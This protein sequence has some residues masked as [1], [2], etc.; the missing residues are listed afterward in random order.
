MDPEN[1]LVDEGATAAPA[2]VSEP[3]R[4]ASMI[5]RSVRVKIHQRENL[6]RRLRSL[7]LGVIESDTFSL[8]QLT[9][10]LDLVER[11]YSTLETLQTQLE[12]LDE[13]QLNEDHRVTFEDTYI[14]AKTALLDQLEELQRVQPL[15]HMSSTQVER[16]CTHRI[17]LPKLQ[18]TKFS[19]EQSQWL[20]FYNVFTTLVHNNKDLT[21]VE[22]FQYL[23][24]CLTDEASRLIQSL[25]VTSKNYNTALDLIVSRFNNSHLI[26]QSHMQQICDLTN[27]SSSNTYLLRNFIDTINVN[28]RAM[29]SLATSE[30]IGEAI[31]LHVIISKLDSATRTKWE[32]EVAINW[33]CRSSSPLNIPTWADLA[34]FLERRCQT[35]NML[36]TNK[37]ANQ[38]STPMKKPSPKTSNKYALAVANSHNRCLLC[39]SSPHHSPFSCERFMNMN[40]LHRYFLVKRLSLCLNCLGKNHTSSNCPSNRRCQQC[41][42]S[43]H[44]LLHR[45]NES[46]AIPNIRNNNTSGPKSENSNQVT[47]KAEQIGGDVILATARIHLCN[48]SGS[49]LI[50]RALLDSGSQLNFITEHIAQHLRLPRIKRSIEVSG[51]GAT[52]TKTHQLCYVTMKS[53]HTEYTSSLEVV[54]IPTITSK[55]PSSRIISKGFQ[56]SNNIKLAD[57]RFSEPGGIDCLIGAGIFFDLLLVGQIKDD[58]RYP[59]LQKTKL[60]WIVSGTAPSDSS[61]ATNSSSSLTSLPTYKTFLAVENQITLDNLVERFWTVEGYNNPHKLLSD[62]ELACEQFFK[63]TTTRCPTSGRFIVRL[64][65]KEK[66]VALGQ[67]YDIAFRRLVAL[68][69]KLSKNSSLLK[70][71]REFIHDYEQMQHM[72]VIENVKQGRN[73]I[74]HHCVMKTDS[75]TTKL[76]VV[77]DASCQTSNGKSLNDVLRVGPTLQDDILTILTRFR[78]HRYVL[79]ADIAKMYRQVLVN[80]ADAPWQCILWR[81]SLQAPV[82]M[83]QMQTVTY[84]TSCAPYLATK[85]LLEA[86]KMESKEF[87]IGSAITLKDFYVDNLMT[88][89]STVSMV[90]EI[91]RQVAAL[92]KG[93]GF[94]LRKFAANNMEIIDDIPLDDREEIITLG[95]SDYVK[96][97]GLKWSPSKDAFFFSYHG[98]AASRK[99]TKRSILSQIAALFDPLGLL[100]PL[101]VAGK[102]L[103]QQLW[104]LKLDWDESVPQDIYTQW[105]A[106]QEHL[107]AI[108]NIQIPR[109]QY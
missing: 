82:R 85:C 16:Q 32:E 20:D 61:H 102:I 24:S 54:I 99:P 93:A 17:N 38:W 87:P 90:I 109:C 55:Q 98:P 86:A 7:H 81:D 73:F 66:P 2:N 103:M 9:A 91:K 35:F 21:E 37:A 18:L 101:I 56:I 41:N 108:N 25:E 95:D 60:G 42:V 15:S 57:E 92:L 10:K 44:T 88:G 63:H 80:D 107:S 50:V 12:E 39:D 75:S 68:E 97:L 69:Y 49:S 83:Y 65:F 33:N 40:P 94:P 29:Q 48:S 78:S 11:Q 106:F 104:E 77:F 45:N 62:N 96:T 3:K 74:P 52:T 59:I 5:Q 6:L 22:K 70:S 72:K 89:A 100:N 71:Y 28:L 43:H 30:Q 46:D 58:I 67:S 53:I 51:I 34:A 14:E 23:R 84:G 1:I 47:M 79:I 4:E 105:R 31:L 36:E 26:F 27:L 76:R 13:S 19:G 64:P 8:R